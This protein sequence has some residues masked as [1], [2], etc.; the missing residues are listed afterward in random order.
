[1]SSF[2][3]QKLMV[4][5][6][7]NKR[8]LPWRKNVS[9]YGVW[10]SEVML[11]QTQVATVIPF[12]LRWMKAFPTLEDLAKAP[13][14]QVIKLWEG[15]GYYSRAR[16]L[17]FGANYIVKYL[18]GKIPDTKE[19]LLKI[20]GIGPYTCGALLSFAFKKRATLIDGN[21]KR[22]ASRFWGLKM[23]FVQKKEYAQLESFLEQSLPISSEWIFNEALMELGA[24]VCTPKNPDCTNCPLNQQCYAYQ[25]QK[26]MSFPLKV[27]RQ[28]SIRLK[29]A[30]FILE[31]KGHLLIEK[32][33]EGVMKD[34]YEFPY[35]EFFSKKEADQK[36][37]YYKTISHQIT[38]MPKVIHTF[39]HHHVTLFP[40]YI[41]I[42][43]KLGNGLWLPL[44]LI[45]KKPFSSGHRKAFTY[46]KEAFC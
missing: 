9:A 27:Q 17:H 6:Q 3:S 35:L 22:V 39:T 19:E 24:T 36:L 14:D 45:E 20:K 26:Q 5:F 38:P 28:K 12:Y 25:H 13:I 7:K 18:N 1:M 37:S 11:Q 16:N 34:L 30:V 41:Q 29:R 10:I 42:K 46:F 15:L 43:E 4:W 31:H 33:D 21:V 40:Y 8:D 32:R 23:S 2:P 44:E